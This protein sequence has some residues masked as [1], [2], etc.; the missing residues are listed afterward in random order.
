MIDVTTGQIIKAE[1]GEGE[2]SSTGVSIDLDIAPSVDF[3]KDGFDETVIGK[4]TRKAVEMSAKTIIDYASDLPWSGR[5][6]KV[7]G[8]QIYLNSGEE[9]GEQIGRVVGI[10]HRGEE[11]V[12]PDTGASL[13]SEET[14]IGT[15]KI[16]KVEKNI[17]L[18]KQQQQM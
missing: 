9:D 4:A 10:Y 14:K 5:V 11:L 1:K 3:G 16:I 12:D 13:G 15:A 6:I 2:D 8:K 17:Q 18:Q 7:S